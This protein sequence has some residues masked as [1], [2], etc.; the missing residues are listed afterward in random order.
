MARYP[1]S[2]PAGEIAIDKLPSRGVSEILLLGL[3]QPLAIPGHATGSGAVP[4]DLE[5]ITPW[6]GPRHGFGGQAVQRLAS[7][8]QFEA[9]ATGECEADG[10]DH[11]DATA[12]RGAGSP[13]RTV[14]PKWPG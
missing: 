4:S 8:L 10:N 13:Y 2:A 11:V 9:P 14:A 12:F 3:P 6:T 1:L 5:R 7:G